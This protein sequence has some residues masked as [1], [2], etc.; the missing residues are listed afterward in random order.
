LSSSI[1]AGLLI[2]LYAGPRYGGG[3]LNR[4]NITG[5]VDGAICW[6]IGGDG[7]VVDLIPFLGRFVC[8]WLL[9]G[10]D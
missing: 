1:I 7:L 5:F 9:L 10:L 8:P 3:S 4:G 2:A 6:T